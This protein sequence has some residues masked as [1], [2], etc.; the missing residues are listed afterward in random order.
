MRCLHQPQRA[1]CIIGMSSYCIR[2][3]Q[4]LCL[5]FIRTPLIMKKIIF[6]IVSLI[7]TASSF[8]QIDPDLTKSHKSSIYQGVDMPEKKNCV[9]LNITSLICKNIAVQYERALA[10]K[11]A[12]ACQIRFMPKGA[13]P[14]S[15]SIKNYIDDSISLNAVKAG[16]FTITPEFR[17]YPKHV[18]K[19]FYIA[20]YF[21]YRH[22]TLDAPVDYTN[23][24]NSTES[25]KLEGKFSTYGGGLMLGSHFNIGESFS[26][27]WFIL[28]A[29]VSST[30]MKLNAGGLSL[31]QD[32]RTDIENELNSQL[33]EQPL[34]KNYSV[35]TTAGGVSL[36][37]SF[38]F[39][40][41]RGF[42]LNFGY[43]F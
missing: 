23:D 19:G 30:K 20:P 33:A 24:N 4:V 28:G 36:E 14:F 29:H 12:V 13:I 16:S 5:Q 21:R 27:D 6:L 1:K 35:T 9:K 34:I 18:M 42:G 32:E 7:F 40:G 41:L 25:I 2:I 26:L 39:F 10:P 22:V 3:K 8:A 38:T 31:S 15:N 43:R 37:G 11:I 17:F